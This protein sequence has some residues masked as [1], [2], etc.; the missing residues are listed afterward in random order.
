MNSRSGPKVRCKPLVMSSQADIVQMITPAYGVQT[1]PRTSY[2]CRLCRNRN[3]ARD[4]LSSARRYSQ[5]SASEIP[6]ASR[7]PGGGPKQFSAQATRYPQL[8]PTRVQ[9]KLLVQDPGMWRELTSSPFPPSSARASARR[10]A[11]GVE[12]ALISDAAPLPKEL[13][14]GLRGGERWTDKP[15]SLGPRERAAQRKLED[16]KAK[17]RSTDALAGGAGKEKNGSKESSRGKSAVRSGL[18]TDPRTPPQSKIAKGTKRKLTPEGGWVS[19]FG[20]MKH[21]HDHRV[22]TRQPACATCAS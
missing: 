13:Q 15:Q 4:L 2:R 21:K 8:Q 6:R 22:R 5:A 9:L 10:R 14:G 19:T 1:S 3:H 17:K 11:M 20:G 18:S 7:P 12:R 16:N